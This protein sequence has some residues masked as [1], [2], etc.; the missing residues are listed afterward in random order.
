MHLMRLLFSIF[1]RWP[2]AVRL[3][4]LLA[5]ALLIVMPSTADAQSRPTLYE[6]NPDTGQYVFCPDYPGLTNRVVMCVGQTIVATVQ[7]FLYNYDQDSPQMHNEIVVTVNVACV[8]AVIIYGL[9]LFLGRADLALREGVLL[10]I[11]IGVVVLL[12]NQGGFAHFFPYLIG[13]IDFLAS[14]VHGFATDRGAHMPGN[15]YC[16]DAALR[17]FVWYRV[18]CTLNYLVGGILPGSTIGGGII[19]FFVAALFSGTVGIAIFI[20]GMGIV[21][22]LLKSLV[23]AIF[24]LL[25]AYLSLAVLSLIAPLMVPM[26]LFRYTFGYFDKWVRLMF[27]VMIQPIFLFAYLNMFLLMIDVTLFTGK[28]S[29]YSAITCHSPAAQGRPIGDVVNRSGALAQ[30]SGQF[31]PFVFSMNQKPEALREFFDYQEGSVDTG[32]SQAGKWVLFSNEGNPD[33]ADVMNE[34]NNAILHTPVTAVS[35]AMLAQKCTQYE[36]AGGLRGASQYVQ[37][38]NVPPGASASKRFELLWKCTY[39]YF[40]RIIFSLFTVITVLY[41]FYAMLQFIPYLGQLISSD[42]FGLPNFANMFMSKTGSGFRDM[43]RTLGIGQKGGSP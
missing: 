35:F 4:M 16:S 39:R 37:C 32:L 7:S 22:V 42:L 6:Q 36:K 33:G 34:D 41:V 30:K 10:A 9:M 43:T 28:Y 2:H 29:V 38:P 15:G 31:A 13:S 25:A 24:V 17:Q 21:L 27:G 23:Q 8:L 12:V 14:S 19:G 26:I 3:A 18:D 20:M 1:Y 5:C 11:K 40:I